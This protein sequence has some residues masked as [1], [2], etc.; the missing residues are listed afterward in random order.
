ML[1][2]LLHRAVSPI[3]NA[4]V[5]DG[6]A[7]AAQRVVRRALRQP[8]DEVLRGEPIGHPLHPALVAVPIG[9]W[10]SA[11]A[12]DLTGGDAAAARRLVALGCLAA[13]PTA[14]AGAADWVR[15]SG[16]SRR[17]GF[18]HAGVND[19]ALL[20]YLA[21]WRARSGGRR[22]RGALL[23]LAGAGALSVGGW[24]GGH[25]TYRLGVNVEMGTD[26]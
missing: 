26:G 9:A 5:L 18:V 8:V 2:K 10:V 11:S 19:A 22:L 20:L 23:A 25:L 4:Q 6:P 7:H 17:V 24:L 21:S 15:T 16:A 14:A 1:E 3:E 12:L 13:F